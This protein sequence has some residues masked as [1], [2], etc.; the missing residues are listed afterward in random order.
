V[1]TQLYARDDPEIVVKCDTAK[2]TG[3]F[4]GVAFS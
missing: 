1:T 2:I 3:D 4:C